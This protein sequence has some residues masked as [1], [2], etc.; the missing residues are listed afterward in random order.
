MAVEQHPS[1]DSSQEIQMD[2]RSTAVILEPPVPVLLKQYSY[3][4]YLHQQMSFLDEINKMIEKKLIN[5]INNITIEID[6]L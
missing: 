2:D 1:K 3:C 5:K 4:L 6:M